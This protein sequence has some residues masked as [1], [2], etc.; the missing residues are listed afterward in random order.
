MAQQHDAPLSDEQRQFLQSYEQIRKSLAD[1]D[2]AG[3]KLAAEKIPG[4]SSAALIA[5]GTDIE[6]VRRDFALLSK[7][8]VKLAHGR[9]GYFIFHCPET[10]LSN[11]DWAHWVQLSKDASN[12]YLGKANPRCGNIMK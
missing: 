11:D 6:S 5:K 1:D 10:K 9:P 2:L 12:P 8:A 7:L 3:A 4:N